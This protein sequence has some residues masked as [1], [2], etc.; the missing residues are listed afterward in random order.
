MLFP[1][2]RNIITITVAILVVTVAVSCFDRTTFFHYHAIDLEGWER[3]D[4][5]EYEMNALEEDGYYVEEIGVRTTTTY[6]F[7]RLN[8]IVKQDIISTTSTHPSRFRCDTLCIDI[9]DSWGKPKGKGIDLYQ[10]VVPLKTLPLKSGDSLSVRI[11]H[12]MTTFSVKGVSDVGLKITR[13]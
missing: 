13:Q 8:L 7:K 11:A 3:M 9:Y 12:C 4:F 5:K 10:H 6:P 2:R 1:L